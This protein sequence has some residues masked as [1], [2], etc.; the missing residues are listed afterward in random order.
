MTNVIYDCCQCTP[1]ELATLLTAFSKIGKAFETVEHLDQAGF[2]SPIL[3]GIVF[4]LPKLRGPIQD[5]LEMIHLKA[6]KE[7]KKEALWTDE[8]KYPEILGLTTVCALTYLFCRT[9]RI[10]LHQAIQVT[11]SELVDELRVGK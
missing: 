10:L 2:D 7:G 4:T 9:S 11:E 8:D 3:N 1:Q 6:A 5:L